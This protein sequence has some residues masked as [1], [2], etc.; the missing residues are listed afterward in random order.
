MADIMKEQNK[1]IICT[2]DTDIIRECAKRMGIKQ[3]TKQT[4]QNILAGLDRSPYFEKSHVYKKIET[5]NGK[6]KQKCR[7]Y[8]FVDTLADEDKNKRE[9]AI[10]KRNALLK[11]TGKTISKI[12]KTIKDI[13]AGKNESKACRDNNID[14]RM[15]RYIVQQTNSLKTKEKIEDFEK[16]MLSPYEKI[17]T[18]VVVS[19]LVH[20]PVWEI[21]FD[22]EET[23]DIALKK[24]LRPDEIEILNE[25]YINGKT[26]QHIAEKKGVKPAKIQYIRNEALRKLRRQ[27]P[28]KLIKYGKDFC[29]KEYELRKENSK[30]LRLKRLKELEEKIKGE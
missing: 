6:R 17:Y 5:K 2:H 11:N 30:N 14:K 13:I 9:A 22:I 27:E 24:Y 3:F 12:D 28:L 19:K 10:K 29:D 16:I 25:I 18:D 20:Y 15:F 4:M 23:M 1:E 8:R 21:P 7:C 26:M